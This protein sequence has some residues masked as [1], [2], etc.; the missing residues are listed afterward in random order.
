MAS[1]LKNV[2]FE[3]SSHP[4]LL[5][6]LEANLLPYILLPLAGPEELDEADS[7]D[8]LTDLQLLPPDKARDSDNDILVTH[9]ET[10][11]LLTTTREGRE[12][13][14]K[15]KVYP[16]IRECHLHVQNEGVKNACERLVQ[17]LMRE[18][19]LDENSRVDEIEDEDEKIEEIF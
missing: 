7:A 4:M 17:V 5:S 10:L 3:I 1:T 14:R 16:I 2:A 12:L 6:D 13:M 9:L 18:E 15:V 19:A 11:L 8:M